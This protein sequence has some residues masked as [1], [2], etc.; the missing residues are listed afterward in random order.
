MLYQPN[1]ILCGLLL[2]FLLNKNINQTSKLNTLVILLTNN[3][4]SQAKINKLIRLPMLGTVLN[5]VF[6]A[7]MK[8]KV[9][10]K[11]HCVI[12]QPTDIEY[13]S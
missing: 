8:F 10:K 2:C 6:C 1:S 11:P 13:L 3:L 5:T 7:E 9:K 12:N 4:S